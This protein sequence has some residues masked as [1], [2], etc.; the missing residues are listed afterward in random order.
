MMTIMRLGARWLGEGLWSDVIE[1][2]GFGSVGDRSGADS[3][4]A[5]V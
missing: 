5:F 3:R 1:L 4:W 2:D